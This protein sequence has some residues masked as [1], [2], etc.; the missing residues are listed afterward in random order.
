MAGISPG[1]FVRGLCGILA[2]RPRMPRSLAANELLRTILQRRTQRKFKQ[3]PIPEEVWE[4]ILEAGRLAPSTV[5]LQTWSLA[6]FTAESWREHF[7][8]P[9]PLGGYRAVIVMADV[10]R[11]R[12]VVKGFP[13][14]PLCGYT[15]GVM[16]ASLAA[17]NINV[18]AEALGVSSCMLSETG[19]TGFYDA[20]HLS[21]A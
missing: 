17:M 21:A 12:R 2:A 6:T 20:R 7:S 8:A 4:A 14:A 9:L 16:N 5:N 11:A 19:R 3:T 15:V 10:H 13:Y 18:A 1:A